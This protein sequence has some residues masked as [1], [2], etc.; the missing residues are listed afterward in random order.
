MFWLEKA[1]AESIRR[2]LSEQAG[3]EFS[4]A[5]V[6]ATATTPP[7]GI[8]V[9]RTRL[10]LGTGEAVFQS[11]TAALRRWEQFRLGWVEA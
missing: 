9:D 3:L 7:V 8:V 2:F 10:T 11:A 5:A 6:G 1:S 4:Y